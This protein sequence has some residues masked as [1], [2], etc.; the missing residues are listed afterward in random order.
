VSYTHVLRRHQKDDP[1]V[2]ERERYIDVSIDQELQFV[3]QAII[4]GWHFNSADDVVDI[5]TRVATHIFALP[6][7]GGVSK[8]I[9]AST[10]TTLIL[11]TLTNY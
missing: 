1:L 5:I 10:T 7:E 2:L 9:H 11:H 3:P 6:G 4:D 8:R